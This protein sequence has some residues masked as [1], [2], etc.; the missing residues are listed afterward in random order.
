MKL[1]FIFLAL[2]LALPSLNC[3]DRKSN[4][5]N[6]EATVLL[7]NGNNVQ[8]GE[9]LLV[10]NQRKS[11][12][13]NLFRK[14]ISRYPAID[15]EK[16]W[17]STYDGIKPIEK[18]IT[19]TEKQLI[20]IKIEQEL[21]EQYRIIK[22]FDYSDFK[23]NLKQENNRRIKAVENKQVIYGPVQYSEEFYYGYLHNNMVLVLEEVMGKEVFTFT[24]KMYQ[25]YYEENKETLF[26]KFKAKSSLL[27]E[28][29]EFSGY[30]KLNE[31]KQQIRQLLIDQEYEKLITEKLL[32]TEIKIVDE[33]IVRDMD[34][35]LLKE[36]I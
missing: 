17:N 11:D 33:D 32:T 29:E 20:R 18:L 34:V 25:N 5:L 21:A 28:N 6:P 9:F 35:I 27:S 15:E 13:M 7:I 14:N 19:E 36:V 3:S 2:L 22:K 1:S 16:F 8:L 24:D 23:H 10:A 4:R 26:K 30:K 31:I 12:I